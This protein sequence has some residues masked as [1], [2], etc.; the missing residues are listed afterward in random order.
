[1]NPLC[2]V[3]PGIRDNR[4]KVPAADC[5][6]AQRELLNYLQREAASVIVSI[7][8]T[9]RMFPVPGEIDALTFDNGEGGVEKDSH[10]VNFTDSA[11]VRSTEGAGK[12]A[13]VRQLLESLLATGGEVVLIYPVPEVGWDVPLLNFKRY[14]SD[15]RVQQ[16]IST[17]A[18]AY[19]KRNAF[20]EAALDA[21][22]PH[23]RLRVVRPAGLLCNSF[24]PNRCLAQVDGEPLYFDDNH[25]SDAGSR[26]VVADVL[27]ALGV[28][29]ADGQE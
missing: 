9:Y 1:M 5:S 29:S 10:R 20:S 16:E 12:R 23:P 27:R 19:R 24:L 15:G 6:S 18:A 3:I 17:S 7:R 2:H 21:V 11:G 26:L 14:L 8:W 13:A 25:L 28:S 4:V 22:G